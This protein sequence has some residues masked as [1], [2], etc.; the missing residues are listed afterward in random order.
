[1]AIHKE[2]FDPHGIFGDH[3]ISSTQIN[4][5][6]SILIL[7][8]ILIIALGGG[9]DVVGV[10]CL[11]LC[12]WGCGFVSLTSWKCN[13]PKPL[14]LFVVWNI[15]LGDL[16]VDIIHEGHSICFQGKAIACSRL[17]RG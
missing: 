17:S 12:G 8:D 5:F 7:I 13:Y 6:F 16:A 9:L 2:H 14:S 10:E 3:A 1:M 15:L 11:F 4:I